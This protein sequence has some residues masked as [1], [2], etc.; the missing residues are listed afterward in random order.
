ME[1]ADR[2]LDR[3]LYLDGHPNL[4]RLNN[5]RVGE[6][7]VEQLRLAL[8]CEREAV[9]KLNEGIALCVEVG[10]NGTRELLAEAIREEEEE[11]LDL[12]ETQ[13]DAIERVGLENYLA[14]HL[15]AAD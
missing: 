3:I 1:D 8:E 5:V 4:Q 11:H 9:A 7:P 10:D 14:Q 12:F 15:H 6:D 2:Y 13:L